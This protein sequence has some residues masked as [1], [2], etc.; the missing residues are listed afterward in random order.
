ME[1]VRRASRDFAAHFN[2]QGYGVGLVVA[3]LGPLFY[4]LFKGSKSAAAEVTGWV[5]S[6]ILPLVALLTA[7]FLWQL[8]CAPYRIL[9]DE[10]TAIR[11]TRIANT[12]PVG[13][14]A[15]PLR[16]AL[17]LIRQELAASAIRI[18][19]ARARS[20]WWTQ[21]DPLP[22]I[23]WN[24]QFGALAD[25]TLPD[26]LRLKAELAYQQCDRLNH[27]VIR[28]MDEYRRRF[29]IVLGYPASVFA[30]RDGD[31]DLLLETR[32]FI[33]GTNSAITDYLNGAQE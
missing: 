30:F 11:D 13:N 26:A 5:L 29:P 6:G 10:I 19:E 14:S 16:V 1:I 33:D 21:S 7:T 27:H 22:G 3:V 28:Y 17:L 31:A 18:N 25:P 9:K 4:W 12:T 2:R 32:R 24:E 8:V 20:S 15:N 23:H